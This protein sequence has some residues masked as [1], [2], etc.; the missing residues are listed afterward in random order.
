MTSRGTPLSKYQ[1]YD[2]ELDKEP[3][4][5]QYVNCNLINC[6]QNQLEFLPTNSLFELNIDGFDL[7]RDLFVKIDTKTKQD[8]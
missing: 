5:L 1:T 2:F 6:F 3:I 8:D 7:N 4:Q